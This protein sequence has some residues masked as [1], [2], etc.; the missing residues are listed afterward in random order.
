MAKRKFGKRITGRGIEGGV[1]L[2]TPDGKKIKFKD[3]ETAQ[4]YFNQHYYNSYVMESYDSS[5][6]TKDKN[7]DKSKNKDKTKPD[8]TSSNKKSSQPSNKG[9]SG[10]SEKTGQTGSSGNKNSRRKQG[11][12][13]NPTPNPVSNPTSDIQSNP[14]AGAQI[15]P[16][17]EQPPQETGYWDGLL[18]SWDYTFGSGNPIWGTQRVQNF[19]RA[20]DINPNFMDNWDLANN[21]AQAYN[22]F[23][24]G[25]MNRLSPTQNIRLLYDWSQGKP[26]FL[27][28]DGQLGGS[29]WGNN[30]I[31]TDKFASEHPGWSMAINGAGDAVLVGGGLNWRT[32]TSSTA[33]NDLATS[34]RNFGNSFSHVVRNPELIPQ[35]FNAMKN[36][37]VYSLAQK[38]GAVPR[39]LQDVLQPQKTWRAIKEGTYIPF[40]TKHAKQ[41]Y[42]APVI[43]YHNTVTVP[44]A[45]IRY[46]K[47]HSNLSQ[48]YDIGPYDPTPFD[49]TTT[50]F[51]TIAEGR[52]RFDL[53]PEA[54]GVNISNPDGS[55]TIFNGNNNYTHQNTLKS[56][57]QLNEIDVHENTHTTQDL[58]KNGQVV[59]LTAEFMRQLGYD[60]NQYRMIRRPIVEWGKN[61]SESYYGVPQ[62]NLNGPRFERLVRPFDAGYGPENGIMAENPDLFNGLTKNNPNYSWESSANELSSEVSAWIDTHLNEPGKLY[63]ELTDFQKRIIQQKVV[64]RFNVSPSDADKMLHEGSGYYFNKGGIIK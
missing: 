58:N 30:G 36:D 28:E 9:K 10:N 12:Q 38:S 27:N 6:D 55:T 56:H 25:L 29:W 62:S 1:T 63:N 17:T 32:L 51:G 59:D 7:K 23:S 49:N 47:L 31:V 42:M 18:K 14:S 44:A 41:R 40:M 50:I 52:K 46:Q 53:D 33:R 37:W 15:N 54:D 26:I 16:S 11:T 21:V 5:S 57:N 43:D 34:Y 20:L 60:P 64:N 24:G 35:R 19:R 4:H 45:K 3:A 48:R 61:G 22:I 8:K 39:Y 2:N 13:S